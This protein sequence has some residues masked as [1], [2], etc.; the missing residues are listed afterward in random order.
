MGKHSEE[1]ILVMLRPCPSVNTAL[2]H[3]R[4]KD[5]KNFGYNY[6]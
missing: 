4:K 3:Y 5:H 2:V 1:V 6:S